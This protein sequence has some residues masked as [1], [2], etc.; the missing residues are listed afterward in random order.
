MIEVEEPT[1][2]P[3]LADAAGQLSAHFSLRPGIR[4][5][6]ARRRSI[7]TRTRGPT[8]KIQVSFSL[9]RVEL[10]RAKKLLRTTP[11]L[12]PTPKT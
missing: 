12:M 10:A 2:G 6:H 11:L 8:F 3:D 7:S 9:A 4:Y 1:C 5:G